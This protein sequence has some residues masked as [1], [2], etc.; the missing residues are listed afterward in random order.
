MRR[1]PSCKSRQ[2]VLAA[3]ESV[4]TPSRHR[5]KRPESHMTVEEVESYPYALQFQRIC[6]RAF[7]HRFIGLHVGERMRRTEV[8]TPCYIDDLR[9]QLELVF[10][11]R[12]DIGGAVQDV[13]RL[14][15]LHHA[16]LEAILS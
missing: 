14:A 10:L 3:L 5:S 2:Q 11:E 8:V 13:A 6:Q 9:R 15:T 7:A 12:T 4:R 16:L 1:R